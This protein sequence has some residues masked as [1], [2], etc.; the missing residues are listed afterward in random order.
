MLAHPLYLLLLQ[1]VFVLSWSSGFIGARLG[2]EDAGAINLLFWRFLLVCLC[3]LPWVLHRLRALT[4][5]KRSPNTS[6]L[7]ISVCR[8]QEVYFVDTPCRADAYRV[9]DWP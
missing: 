4:W 2:T 3:L 7:M 1:G 5:G 8:E 9:C 6:C